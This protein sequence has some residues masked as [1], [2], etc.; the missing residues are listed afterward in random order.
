MKVGRLSIS[1][2]FLATTTSPL[3]KFQSMACKITFSNGSPINSSS[4]LISV[5]HVA[6][7]CT[8]SNGKSWTG[9][10]SI[11]LLEKKKYMDDTYKLRRNLVLTQCRQR[12]PQ[13]NHR[14][15]VCLF[16]QSSKC[17]SC[18]RTVCG[19]APC[20]RCPVWQAIWARCLR[21]V[22]AQ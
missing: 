1:L 22:R 15:S 7:A 18:R 17:Q 6:I 14:W 13:L 10:I 16:C 5:W 21:P 8:V 20:N 4:K 2:V 3:V 12:L 11:L 9:V 19:M